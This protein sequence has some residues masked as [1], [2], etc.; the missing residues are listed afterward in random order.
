LVEQYSYDI[1][2]TPTIRDGSGNLLSSS[3]INNRWLF[4]GRDWDAGEQLYQYRYRH[5]SASLGR[6]M[7]T[8]PIR[9]WPQVDP[10]VHGPSQY[11]LAEE[12]PYNPYRYSYNSPVNW[13]DPDGAEAACM[14]LGLGWLLGGGGATAGTAAAGGVA[15]GGTLSA[16]ATGGLAL[17]AGAVSA[18]SYYV[19]DKLGV[20]D[21]I[22]EQ[23]GRVIVATEAIFESRGDP[24]I[25]KAGRKKQ[26]R[27]INEGKRQNPDWQPR[28]PQRPLKPHTPGRDHRR[29]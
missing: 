19:S 16:A 18:G 10:L 11:A 20:H 6:F 5:Y 4:T 1:Y 2:G 3:A 9:R 22:A 27:E 23:F 29:R 24:P 8:D 13:L 25:G 14:S 28:G 17:Y 12:L 21:W 15:A 7:Q 26:G